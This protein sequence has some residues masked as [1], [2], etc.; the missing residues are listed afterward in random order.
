MTMTSRRV[1]AATWVFLALVS[2]ACASTVAPRATILDDIGQVQ[3]S[4]DYIVIGGG[5]SGLTVAARLTEDPKSK[6]H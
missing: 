3:H 6:Q 5:T 1:R 4:Y 2:A